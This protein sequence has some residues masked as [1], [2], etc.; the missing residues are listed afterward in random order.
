MF[1]GSVIRLNFLVYF[2]PIKSFHENNVYISSIHFSLNLIRNWDPNTRFFFNFVILRSFDSKNKNRLRNIF[3]KVVNAEKIWVELEKM[4]NLGFINFSQDSIYIGRNSYNILSIFLF[5]VYLSEFDYY[6]NYFS[7]KCNLRKYFYKNK[8]SN[9]LNKDHLSIK[10]ENVL[11]VFSTLKILSIKNL[12]SLQS[13]YKNKLN[14]YII[15]DRFIQWVRFKDHFLFGMVSSKSFSNFLK[16]KL[17][18]F[19]TSTLHFQIKF[20]NFY[21]FKESYVYFGGFVIKLFSFRDNYSASKLKVNKKYFSRLFFRLELMN[22]KVSNNFLKRFNTELII[23]IE[24]IFTDK[25]LNIRTFKDRKLWTYIFQLE[26]IRSTQFNKLLTTKD[27]VSLVANELFSVIKSFD[28][29][30]YKRYLFTLFVHKLQ[31]ALY[32]VILKFPSYISFSF[33]PLDT[34]LNSLFLEFRKKLF[35]LYTNFYF[36][37][38]VYA[39]SFFSKFYLKKFGLISS[40]YNI[41]FTNSD[42]YFFKNYY[43]KNKFPNKFINNV[44]FEIFLPID[45]CFLK[46]RELGFMHKNKN[47]PISNS[48]YLFLEDF[49]IIQTYGYIAYIFLNWFRCTSNITKLKNIINLIRQSCFLTL[50]RKHNKNK[51]WAYNMYTSD[52]LIIGNFSLLKSFFPTKFYLM[53]LKRKFFFSQSDAFLDEQFFL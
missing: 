32:Q 11:N 40:K 50:C 13:Y 29:K 18:S 16:K 21:D 47:R 51:T 43:F 37:N 5:E 23:Q 2:Y 26:S 4:I 24:K 31:L 7:F 22:V 25:R 34:Y 1:E 14:E 42:F 10:L 45:Y 20:K 6:I 44:S 35:F 48:K 36:S 38:N 41:S 49:Q 12:F 3:K 19:V 15:F 30:V 53:N 39:E 28:N 27:E 8:L 17:L 46:L 9:I 33:L 52:L